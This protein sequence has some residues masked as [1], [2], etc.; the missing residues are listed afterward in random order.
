MAAGTL[1]SLQSFSPCR[2]KIPNSTL[3]L[4]RTPFISYRFLGK[5]G[6]HDWQPGVCFPSCRQSFATLRGV[7]FSRGAGAEL[8]GPEGWPPHRL[9]WDN[10][11]GAE[12][13]S[14]A[15]A[16]P[17]G[18][19]PEG[20]PL[21]GGPVGFGPGGVPLGGGPVGL[22]PVGLGPVGLGPCGFPERGV[23]EGLGP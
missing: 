8:D 4:V 2:A 12:A 15:E 10:S 20:F 6:T 11:L 19:G 21:G 23:P 13:V 7:G 16:G 22:R 1:K 14:P 3:L 17:V 5:L 9:R 18:L